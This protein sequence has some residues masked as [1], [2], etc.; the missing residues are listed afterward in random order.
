ML[1]AAAL[2]GALT[3]PGLAM[4]D[5][6]SGGDPTSTSLPADADITVDSIST[7]MY[8]TCGVKTDGSL[9]CWGYDGYGQV[10]GPNAAADAFTRVSGGG[11]HTCGLKEDGGLACWGQDGYGQVSGPNGSS[12]TFVQVSGVGYHTCGVKADGSL[13]CWG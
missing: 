11:Y 8:H 5:G 1:L 6:P 13:T 3:S 7:G 12:D 9:V 4:A 10:S 2:V